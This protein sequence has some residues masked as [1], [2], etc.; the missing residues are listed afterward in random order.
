[1]G[2]VPVLPVWGDKEKN[3]YPYRKYST[4]KIPTIITIAVHCMKI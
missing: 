1:V 4:H 2:G 3:I